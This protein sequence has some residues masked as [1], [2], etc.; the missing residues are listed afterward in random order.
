MNKARYA[1]KSVATVIVV[2]TT[3]PNNEFHSFSVW[4]F[5]GLFHPRLAPAFDDFADDPRLVFL[6]LDELQH[7]VRFVGGDDAHHA[8][9][10]V[11]DLIELVVRH[12]AFFSDDL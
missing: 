5:L 12:A 4:S 11:E 8:D 9:A 1:L 7:G 10:H 2:E 6:A 3:M